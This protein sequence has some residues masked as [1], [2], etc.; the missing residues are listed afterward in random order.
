MQIL[1]AFDF[2]KITNFGS[3]GVSLQ[4]IYHAAIV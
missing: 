4:M 1:R 2:A 3:G